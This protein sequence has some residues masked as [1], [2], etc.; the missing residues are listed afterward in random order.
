MTKLVGID[1]GRARV[2]MAVEV[3]FEDVDES[4][5]LPVFRELAT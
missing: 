3:D 4:V 5:S 2:G 1:A